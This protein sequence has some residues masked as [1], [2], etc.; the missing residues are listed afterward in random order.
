MALN[1][2]HLPKTEA[3]VQELVIQQYSKVKQEI[4]NDIK[5]KIKEQSRFSL[6]MDEWTSLR[7]RRYLNLCLY[8]DEKTFYNLGMVF[9]PGK[10]GA[11]KIRELMEGRLTEFNINFEKHI[12]STITDGPH[13]MK[14]FVRESPVDGIFCHN[15]AIHLAVVD[16]FYKKAANRS[17]VASESTDDDDFDCD[18]F[19][20]NELLVLNNNYKTVIEQTRRIIKIFK[21]SAAKNCILQKYVLAEQ[22]KEISLDLDVVTRWNSM[23]PMIKK[24]LLL[25]ACIK[26][27]L[28]ELDI[29][30]LW[31]EGNIIVLKSLLDVLKP[32]QL[33]VEA[34]GRRDMNLLKADAIVNTLCQQL[35]L[36]HTAIGQTMFNALKHRIE[37]RREKKLY[38]LIK[39]LNDPDIFNK[40]ENNLFTLA[41]KSLIV[42]YAECLHNRL[43]EEITEDEEPDSS[44]ADSIVVEETFEDILNAAINNVNEKAKPKSNKPTLYSIKKDL[45]FFEGCGS[46]PETVQNLYDA[47]LTIRPTSVESERV[48]SITGIFVNK[49]RNRL[50]DESINAYSVLKTYFKNKG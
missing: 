36:N 44:D 49:I 23:V 19:D 28:I 35:L 34:L 17:A 25:K 12:V 14:K 42:S 43:F 21:K 13:V 46:K 9:I 3:H 27:S 48:F 50:S 1:G 45:K 26:K 32:V 2:F 39:Y 16:V 33:A 29:G 18:D 10:C 6:V 20:N 31:I 7:N 24:F 4:I 11:M 22:N 5:N 38:T 30:E 8:G 47:L 37:E 15:H 40:N 41:T